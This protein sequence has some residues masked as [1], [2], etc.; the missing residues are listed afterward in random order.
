MLPRAGSSSS[1][2]TGRRVL[3]LND[4]RSRANSAAADKVTDLDLDDITSAQLAVDREVKH[5]A[6]AQA[7]LAVEPES[8]GPDLLRLQRPLGADLPTGVPRRSIFG[9]RII[10]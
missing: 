6:I 10:L 7:A 2:C 3:L 5:R 8:D 4:D 1:N 9:A